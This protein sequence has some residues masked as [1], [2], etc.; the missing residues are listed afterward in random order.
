[1]DSELNSSATPHR[2]L[3]LHVPHECPGFTRKTQSLDLNL[4][5]FPSPDTLSHAPLPPGDYPGNRGFSLA[6]F[7]FQGEMRGGEEMGE[8][9]SFMFHDPLALQAAGKSFPG[10]S[11]DFSSNC[12]RNS[13]EISVLPPRIGDLQVEYEH[14]ILQ[15]PFFL[16]LTHS[17]KLF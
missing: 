7:N 5:D 8:G 11:S 6:V 14:P 10:P 13:G 4:M 12:G 2:G 15:Y 17:D 16:P 3:D 9:R 1:M